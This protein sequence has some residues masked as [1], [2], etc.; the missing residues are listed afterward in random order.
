M[1][2]KYSIGVLEGCQ[3]TPALCV[4]RHV[5]SCGGG[6]HLTAEFGRF[7]LFAFFFFPINSLTLEVSNEKEGGKSR[8]E[9]ALEEFCH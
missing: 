6:I 8:L 5:C 1:L 4:S 2:N 9:E 7:K 3:N